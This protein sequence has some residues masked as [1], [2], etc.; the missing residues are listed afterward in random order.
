MEDLQHHMDHTD[1]LITRTAR[2]VE[3]AYSAAVGIY[4]WLALRL[5]NEHNCRY[6]VHAS[7]QH[8]SNNFVYNVCYNNSNVELISLGKWAAGL[9]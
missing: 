1:G 8:T 4:P 7:Y 3:R 6:K 2:R 9:L 5:A